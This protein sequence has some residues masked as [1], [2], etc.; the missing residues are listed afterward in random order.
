M[1]KNKKINGREFQSHPDC[2]RWFKE[3]S[4]SNCA[5]ISF[6]DGELCWH[7]GHWRG[8]CWYGGNWY[9]G[10]WYGGHWH[11]G[12][13]Y[14]GHW[15]GGVFEKGIIDEMDL[16]IH[17]LCKWPIFINRK[18]NTIEIGCEVRYQ[19]EWD[20]FFE[21]DEVIET[22]RNTEEFNRIQDGFLLAK[23]MLNRNELHM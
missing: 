5:E 12:V 3:A 16:R 17:S 10:H 4:I 23:W 11:D 20:R 8:R 9:G 13:W 6:S 2:P 19:E 18:K 7:A 14:G 22:P 21:S 15:H 1:K